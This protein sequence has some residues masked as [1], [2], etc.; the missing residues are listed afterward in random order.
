ML[1]LEHEGKRA[2]RDHGVATPRGALVADAAK[3]REASSGL[4][5][6]LMVK[7]QILAGGRG[8]AGGILPAA[9]ADEAASLAGRLLGTTIK[10]ERVESVLIE[11]AAA[12]HRERYLAVLLDGADM[13]CLIGK[14]GGVEVE[15]FFSGARES[16]ETIQIDPAYGLGAYQVRGALE[17]L[18]IEPALWPAFSAVATQLAGLLRRCDATLAEI[19]PLAELA[20]GSLLALDA[21]VIVDDG[22]FFRQPEFA[23]IAQSRSPGD[24]IVA[25]MKALEIQYAPL[26]GSIGLVSS[27]AGVGV[28]I[29]D[30]VAREGGR[31]A[32]FV[33]LDYAIIAGH[34]EPAL[35]LVL[36]HLADDPEIRSIIVNFTTCGLRLDFI[37]R[38]LLTVFGERPERAAKPLSIHL[39]GNRAGAAHEI[40]REGGYPICEAL[41]DAVRQATAAAGKA[42]A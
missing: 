16:F 24:G 3:A 33:D 14:S 6:P 13:L 30:W 7:A 25:R 37:A 1:L 23:A 36:D 18:G 20:D 35:R 26:G 41:G 19:N 39:Q 31:V 21:R 27:G 8:K 34:T 10:G 5:G 42:R 9:T 12:V 32:A 17:R 15:T 28:T 38:S 40:L 29:M 2:L 11:E 4:T 22:A